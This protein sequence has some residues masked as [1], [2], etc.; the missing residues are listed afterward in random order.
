MYAPA[1]DWVEL[2]R[3]AEAV[4]FDL[5]CLSDHVFYPD[6]LESRYP[7]SGDGRPQFA[8]HQ[9]WP[10]VWV[11]TGAMAAVTE[12][13]GFTT[14][15]YVL[16]SR[17]PFVVAKAVGT[18]AWASGGRVAL[19][20]G[21]GWMREEF[22]AME[23]PFARRGARMEEQMAVLRTLWRGGMQSYHG[24]F[25]DFD[26]VDMSPA[27]PGPVPIL[28]G[29]HSDVA[30]RRAARLGDGWVGV[31]YGMDELR[32]YLD[33]LHGY[34]QEYG[35]ADRPFDIQAAVV[36]RLPT[37]DVCAELEAMGVTTMITSAWM[38]AG[39]TYASLDDN[40]RALERFAADYIEPLG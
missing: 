28:V 35:T 29:G 37:P 27:P 38:M 39:L 14:N 34:R 31:Q 7:Y 18:A 17:N 11:M 30:L 5:V 21:A 26:P 40:K 15:V 2:T 23:Q 12:R 32:D 19:G 6:K 10:D 13:I 8:P 20:V 33:R 4:G 25:Y 1:E 9:P 3:H 22:D 36:D 24:E 16:P